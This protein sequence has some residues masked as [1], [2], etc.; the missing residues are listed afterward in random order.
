[1]GAHNSEPREYHENRL[2]QKLDVEHHFPDKT[3]I[4]PPD[5]KA[6]DQRINC[7]KEGSVQPTSALHNQLRNLVRHIRLCRRCLDVLQHP[8]RI[9]LGDQLETQNTIL[10]EVH[11]RGEDTGISTMHLFTLEILF[12]RP[13]SVGVVLQRHVPVC[14]EGTREHRDETEHTFEW[15][16]EDVRHLIQS[17]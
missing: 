12:E 9:P 14:G 4:T 3:V 17:A 7:R 15:F 13:N 16:V 11:I 10:G 6:V 2:I 8:M 1:M 5:V